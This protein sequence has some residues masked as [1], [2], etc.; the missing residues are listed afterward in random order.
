M[1]PGRLSRLQGAWP[2]LFAVGVLVLLYLS[3]FSDFMPPYKR[4]Y[5]QVT[6]DNVLHLAAF[7]VLGVVAPLAFAGRRRALLAL[8]FLLVLG[9]CLELW[10]LYI[11]SRRCQLSDFVGNAAGLLVGGSVGFWLRRRLERAGA[12]GDKG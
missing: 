11:P 3:L 5:G 2:L 6:L 1:G 4:L 7:A 10:Q 9:L 12:L 8:F